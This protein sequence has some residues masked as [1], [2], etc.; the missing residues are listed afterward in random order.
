ME[1]IC[2]ISM[3]KTCEGVGHFCS[4]Y[5]NPWLHW[6]CLGRCCLSV[7]ATIEPWRQRIEWIEHT[8]DSDKDCTEGLVAIV[9]ST[10]PPHLFLLLLLLFPSSILSPTSSGLGANSNLAAAAAAVAAA[11]ATAAA[12]A[13]AVFLG[14]VS[15]RRHWKK[16]TKRMVGSSGEKISSNACM[17]L[18]LYSFMLLLPGVFSRVAR[19][20]L[21]SDDCYYYDYSTEWEA[22]PVLTHG[23]G[24]YACTHSI[25]SFF[26]N[27]FDGR[28]TF[29]VRAQHLPSQ[30]SSLSC[31]AF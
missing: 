12:T 30:P 6:K 7:E 20:Q 5:T 11:A 21:P 3:A 23:N 1:E 29:G 10:P 24:A 2:S 28:R 31:A 8:H 26:V 16:M 25:G 22:A 17:P 15:V 13:A 4:G 19:T 18:N 27:R 9:H 14:T